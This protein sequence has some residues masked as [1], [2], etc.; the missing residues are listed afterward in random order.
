M[1]DSRTRTVLGQHADLGRPLEPPRWQWG[2]ARLD[3]TGR[4]VL[5]GEAR[6]SL[7][8]T[9]GEPCIVRGVCHRVALVLPTGGGTGAPVRVDGRG[10]LRLRVWL[11]GAGTASGALLVG[12]RGDAPLVVVAAAPVL[13]GLCDVL[14]GESR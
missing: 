14:A 9:V 1:T 7:G 11:R 6:A 10:R 2:I 8:V 4:I 13:D 12:A 5:P 3:P